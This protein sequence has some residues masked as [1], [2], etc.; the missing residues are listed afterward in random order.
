[1]NYYCEDIKQDFKKCLWFAVTQ[2][3]REMGKLCPRSTA[4]TTGAFFIV[5]NV[6]QYL[7]PLPK[8]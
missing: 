6:A 7:R 8:S 5:S 3:V 1:M 4:I 2:V